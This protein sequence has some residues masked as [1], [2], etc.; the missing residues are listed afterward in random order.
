MPMDPLL[1]VMNPV[2]WSPD[3][4]LSLVRFFQTFSLS[5]ILINNVKRNRGELWFW[6]LAWG[7]K[8]VEFM[9]GILN[10]WRK[11]LSLSHRYNI[12]SLHWADK[13]FSYHHLIQGHSQYLIYRRGCWAWPCL[14]TSPLEPLIIFHFSC[15]LI[16]HFMS[17]NA[18]AMVELE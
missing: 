10:I 6:S 7:R 3:S 4:E 1:L 18:S 17:F 12:L 15:A 14:L 9:Q 2:S 8:W 13:P 11:A 5:N 16:H